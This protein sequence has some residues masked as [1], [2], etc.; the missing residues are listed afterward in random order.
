MVH[1]HLEICGYC[2]KPAY[3][4]GLIFEKNDPAKQGE[5][6]CTDCLLHAWRDTVHSHIVHHFVCERCSMKA[7]LHFRV[8]WENEEHLVCEQC[9]IEIEQA[10]RAQKREIQLI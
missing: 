2:C 1:F 3:A 8:S 5:T 4:V 10:Q 9:R 7:I 6:W